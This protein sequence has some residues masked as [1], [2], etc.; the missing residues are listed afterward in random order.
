M[1]VPTSLRKLPFFLRKLTGALVPAALVVLATVSPAGAAE[2]T[3]TFRSGRTPG[4][5]DRVEVELDV[6]GDLRV[7][8]TGGDQRGSSNVKMS[9]VARLNYEEKSFAVPSAADGTLRSVRHYDK[10]EAVIKVG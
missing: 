2:G 1:T 10:A 4:A 7:A 6:G 9:A 5:I 8:G 3:W